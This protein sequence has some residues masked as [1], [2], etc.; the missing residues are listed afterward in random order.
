[1]YLLI[2]TSRSLVFLANTQQSRR[3]GVIIGAPSVPSSFLSLDHWKRAFYAALVLL[4]ASN[5]GWMYVMVDHGV[6]DTYSEVA[7]QETRGDLGVMKR[8]VPRAAP[9]TRTDAGAPAP[10]EPGRFHRG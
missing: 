3:A 2:E 5:L 4:V 6:T 9:L 1:V 10:D 8:L 7:N